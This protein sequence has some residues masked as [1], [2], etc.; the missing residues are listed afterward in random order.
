MKPIEQSILEYRI[1]RHRPE[2]VPAKC[3][4]YNL[5]HMSRRILIVSELPDNPGMSITNAIEYVAAAAMALHDYPVEALLHGN[6]HLGFV[7]IEHYPDRRTRRQRELDVDVF[8]AASWDRV[9]FQTWDGNRYT[10]KG[11]AD[12]PWP[13]NRTWVHLDVI[14]VLSLIG[15]EA[16]HYIDRTTRAAVEKHRRQQAQIQKENDKTW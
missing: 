16:Y 9:R 15:G 13:A 1:S 12:R 11:K 3:R 7:F 14:K 10:V 2:G 4:L 5:T 6:E 8:N